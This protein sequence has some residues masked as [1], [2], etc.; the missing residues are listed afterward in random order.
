MIKIN[1]R[2]KINRKIEEKGEK[3][4]K[5]IKKRDSDPFFDDTPLLFFLHLICSDQ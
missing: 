3:K 1:S 4:N 5:R 2:K